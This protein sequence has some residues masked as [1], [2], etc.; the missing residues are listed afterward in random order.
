M[1]PVTPIGIAVILAGA[2]AFCIKK[3][4]SNGIAFACDC[5]NCL[6]C[7]IDT[8]EGRP[9]NSFFNQCLPKKKSKP[10]VIKV[11]YI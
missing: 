8:N 9:S 7:K 10:E 2:V 11:A 1:D 6:S 5:C 4:S 3:V